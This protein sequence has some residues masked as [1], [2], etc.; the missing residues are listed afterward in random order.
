MIDIISRHNGS[1]SIISMVNNNI[2]YF[3]GSES[4][5]LLFIQNSISSNIFAVVVHLFCASFRSTTE[6]T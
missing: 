2:Y 5:A 6:F 4:Q 1:I 3:Y